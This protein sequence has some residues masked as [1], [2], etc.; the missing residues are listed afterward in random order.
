MGELY[1][2]IL[3]ASQ[4]SIAPVMSFF[5]ILYSLFSLYAYMGLPHPRFIQVSQ[6]YFAA[7]KLS[8]F[9]LGYLFDAFCYGTFN[10]WGDLSFLLMTILITFDA[11]V[12]FNHLLSVQHAQTT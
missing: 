6:S 3:S 4:A 1:L 8:A 9:C 10:Q 5:V 7:T 12:G 11:L 2:S